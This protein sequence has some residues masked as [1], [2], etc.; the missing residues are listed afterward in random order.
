MGNQ[1]IRL[2]MFRLWSIIEKFCGISNFWA[3]VQSRR[4]SHF[5]IFLNRFW[6][7]LH[8]C[9]CEMKHNIILIDYIYYLIELLYFWNFIFSIFRIVSAVNKI[10]FL[11]YY[12]PC[13]YFSWIFHILLKYIRL[14]T[15]D[16]MTLL[17]NCEWYI[18]LVKR[19]YH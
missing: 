5:A 14:M 9:I 17:I 12:S 10:D 19:I 4:Q 18:M 7:I 13:F 8:P 16:L 11:F 2:G 3:V 1:L 15:R 6:T